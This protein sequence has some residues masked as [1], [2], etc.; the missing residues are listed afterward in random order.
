MSCLVMKGDGDG[1][2]DEGLAGR[3]AFARARARGPFVDDLMER[4]DD[5]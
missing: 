1:D 3:R 5:G 2:G 4:M